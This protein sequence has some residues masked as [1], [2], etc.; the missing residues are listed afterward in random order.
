MNGSKIR[1]YVININSVYTD[2]PAD[3]VEKEQEEWR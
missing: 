3:F 1:F 2:I